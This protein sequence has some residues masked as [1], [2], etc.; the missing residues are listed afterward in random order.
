MGTADRLD[1][2]LGQLDGFAEGATVELELQ[3]MNLLVPNQ[4]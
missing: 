2:G 1:Q 3:G 4:V